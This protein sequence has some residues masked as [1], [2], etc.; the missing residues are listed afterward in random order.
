MASSLDTYFGP[1]TS[2]V[3]AIA[4]RTTGWPEAA[5]NLRATLDKFDSLQG[6]TPRSPDVRK[7]RRA[8]ARRWVAE[9]GENALDL[10]ERSYRKL[11]DR[12]LTVVTEQSLIKTALP[13]KFGARRVDEY[14]CSVCHCSPCYCDDTD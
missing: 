14:L 8:A 6:G 1:R 10:L 13:M 3:E 5:E 4:I 12:G 7:I 2:D 9:Y 11:Q